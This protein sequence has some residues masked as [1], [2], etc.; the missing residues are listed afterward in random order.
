MLSNDSESTHD[1]DHGDDKSK[2]KNLAVGTA[3]FR[4]ASSSITGG[5]ATSRALETTSSSKNKEQAA[6]A[7]QV[8]NPGATV[9]DPTDP[10][11]R[12]VLMP[13]RV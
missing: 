6:R 12:Y 8:S 3:A 13:L 5:V 1:S 10:D 4:T 11:V 7:A 9:V 2:P